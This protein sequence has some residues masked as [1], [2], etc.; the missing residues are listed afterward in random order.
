MKKGSFSPHFCLLTG[1]FLVVVML[2]QALVVVWIDEQIPVATEGHNVVNDG[3]WCP[4]P[5]IVRREQPATLAAERFTQQLIRP[6]LICPD[7]ELVPPV[8]RCAAPPAVLWLVFLT[9]A[10]PGQR[11]A[12]RMLAWS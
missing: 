2:T 9:P 1:G 5:W 11:R 3:S 10:I 6:E 4:V 12:S 7:R 8:I